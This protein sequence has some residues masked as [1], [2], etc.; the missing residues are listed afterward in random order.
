MSKKEDDK[1]IK[2]AKDWVEVYHRDKFKTAIIGR[3]IPHTYDVVTK[4]NYLTA[5]LWLKVR[6]EKVNDGRKGFVQLPDKPN[7]LVM[8][9]NFRRKQDRMIRVMKYL[10]ERKKRST[11]VV[12]KT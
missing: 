10:D 5:S 9:R 1:K 2:M 12:P 6:N 8:V 3:E 7:W 4:V 11:A